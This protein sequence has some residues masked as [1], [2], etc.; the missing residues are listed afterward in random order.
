LAEQHNVFEFPRLLYFQVH[1]TT[2]SVFTGQLT[3]AH[4]QNWVS[5]E[6]GNIFKWLRN[7]IDVE[8]YQLKSKQ[9]PVAIF[10]GEREDDKDLFTFQKTSKYFRDVVF[11]YALLPEVRE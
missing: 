10:Y 11:A 2:P 6:A 7:P 4:I 5:R 8:I 1:A 9:I 3:S